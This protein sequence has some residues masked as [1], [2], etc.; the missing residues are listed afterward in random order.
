MADIRQLRGK[1]ALYLRIPW[2]L[3]VSVGPLLDLV[4]EYVHDNSENPLRELLIR[5]CGVKDQP[6]V[7]DLR[8]GLRVQL[9]P[10]PFVENEVL[11]LDLR[12]FVTI[13]LEQKHH[14][15]RR[16]PGHHVQERA[17]EH[18]DVKRLRL[19]SVVMGEVCSPDFGRRARVVVPSAAFV[20]S[21]VLLQSRFAPKVSTRH[22]LEIRELHAH[23]L[24][25]LG[26]LQ[27]DAIKRQVVVD[28]LD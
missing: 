19:L 10:I 26:Q 3:F 2:L 12:L 25:I 5:R 13:M 20:C 8:G 21:Q 9:V 28:L 16:G 4:D 15:L 24:T 23:M 6:V 22:A 14:V 7:E 17:A 27:C 1:D 11:V 18:E